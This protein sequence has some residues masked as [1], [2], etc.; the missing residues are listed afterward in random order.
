M[1]IDGSQACKRRSQAPVALA[2]AAIVGLSFAYLVY[3]FGSQRL[4][5]IRGQTRAMQVATQHVQRLMAEQANT[6]WTPTAAAAPYFRDIDEVSKRL[7]SLAQAP[8]ER[9]TWQNVDGQLPAFRGA[10]VGTLA[11]VVDSA[12]DEFSRRVSDAAWQES[13]RMTSLGITFPSV[14]SLFQR[15]L[16]AALPPQDSERWLRRA[17][18]TDIP[19]T[20]DGVR[21]VLS[22]DPSDAARSEN[23]R[24]LEYV[25]DARVREEYSARWTS[26]ALATLREA[27]DLDSEGR[28]ADALA[29]YE[30]GWRLANPSGA[31]AEKEHTPVPPV[32]QDR[33]QASIAELSW[34]GSEYALALVRSGRADTALL[35]A[36]ETKDLLARAG[37]PRDSISLLRAAIA[38]VAVLRALNRKVEADRAWLQV[39][40]LVEVERAIERRFATTGLATS[41]AHAGEVEHAEALLCKDMLCAYLAN[42]RAAAREAVQQAD[43]IAKTHPPMETALSGVLPAYRRWLESSE[44]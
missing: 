21:P 13:E 7:P 29:R 3:H 37:E 36:D 18:G 24:W 12:P 9:P 14:E 20:S 17:L 22:R 31:T 11:Q 16:A 19:M 38:R 26:K 10:F 33:P 32:T 28:P 41:L 8:H 43:R 5:T 44:P 30:L 35:I 2:A 6:E 27:W 4:A 25:T 39:V 42:D 15:K 34:L 23:V 40:Q 1:S